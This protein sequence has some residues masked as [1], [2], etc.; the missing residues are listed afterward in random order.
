MLDT[1]EHVVQCPRKS[2]ERYN[3][4]PGGGGVPSFSVSGH[5][6]LDPISTSRSCWHDVMKHHTSYNA[7]WLREMHK[8]AADTWVTF[9]RRTY[10]SA[11]LLDNS[12]VTCF[13][14]HITWVV[15]H[16]G[17]EQRSRVFASDKPCR[18]V[19]LTWLLI[20]HTQRCASTW[21]V[22]R[23]NFCVH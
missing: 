17:S 19:C 7:R 18:Y 20:S 3:N 22:T 6:E 10:Q 4:G 12:T 11:G 9:L 2:K 14:W 13:T 15:H 1:A 16:R 23:T 21:S 8:T 5:P